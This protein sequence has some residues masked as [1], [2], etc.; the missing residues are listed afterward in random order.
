MKARGDFGWIRGNCAVYATPED[1]TIIL[2]HL[3]AI[4]TSQTHDPIP[5]I[6][7]AKHCVNVLIP[8]ADFGYNHFHHHYSIT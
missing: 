3:K 5:S 1:H 4:I 6:Q 8:V 2:S 7:S